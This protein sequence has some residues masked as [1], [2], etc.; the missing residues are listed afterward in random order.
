MPEERPVCICEW[1]DGCGGVGTVFCEGC[2]GDLCVCL[3]GGE[4]PCRG[5]LECMDDEDYEND[6]FRSCYR[7]GGRGYMVTCIDDLCHGQDECIHGDDP[8][9]CPEC[10]PKGDGEDRFYA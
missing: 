2:G 5:C 3:C 7:C 10:N 8:T 9:P 1:A 6:A 4:V